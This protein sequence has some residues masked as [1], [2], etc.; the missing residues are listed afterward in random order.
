MAVIKIFPI[1]DTFIS[2]EKSLSNH[3]KDEMLE[4]G[5]YKTSGGGETLRTFIKFNRTEVEQAIAAISASS[6]SENY[7]VRLKG[8]LATANELPYSFN[9]NLHP[10]SQSW[11]P[12]TGKFGDQPSNLTGCSWLY[13]KAGSQDQWM[14]ASY[15]T[16]VTASFED[17]LKGGGVW[18]TSSASQSF[19]QNSDLDLDMVVTD[20]FGSDYRSGS[21]GDYGFVLKL[22]DQY[23]FNASSSVRLKYFSAD[24]NTIYPPH[25]EI[26]STAAGIFTGSLP[27]IT[28]SEFILSV[29]NN[30][31][32]YTTN[33]D[34]NF[35]GDKQRFRLHCRPKYPTR[36]FTTSS[37]YINNHVLPTGSFWGLKDENT[38]EMC[39]D[40]STGTYINHD[41]TS[42]YFDMFMDGLQPERYYRLLV[43][44][45]VDGSTIIADTNEVFKIVRNG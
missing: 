29:R 19:N 26:Q 23:E 32:E 38:E 16:G 30:K 34:I 35:T 8:S 4:V 33:N 44:T 3:G 7:T 37:A 1:E 5:G 10:L 14:T 6:N 36:T 43:K 39:I 15:A 2:T 21:L 17:D 22:E 40:F 25:I 11:D 41:A 20:L 31:G 28:D 27:S 13:R 45:E 42:M 12:G 9:L 24:T 18:Y